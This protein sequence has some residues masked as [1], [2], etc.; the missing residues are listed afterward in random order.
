[1]FPLLETKT[2]QWNIQSFYGFVDTIQGF[3]KKGRDIIHSDPFQI[4]SQHLGRVTD[5]KIIL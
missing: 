5:L 2:Q 1:M 4:L 3:K